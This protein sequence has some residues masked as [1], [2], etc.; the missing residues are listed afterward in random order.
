MTVYENQYQRKY[1]HG[2]TVAATIWMSIWLAIVMAIFVIAGNMDHHDQVAV[3]E[4][5]QEYKVVTDERG[6]PQLVEVR[7][8]QTMR[9]VQ[10][11][12]TLPGD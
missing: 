1:K 12:R 3:E 10:A 9:Q 2:R 7:N 8:A 4:F 11:T 6:E 5:R